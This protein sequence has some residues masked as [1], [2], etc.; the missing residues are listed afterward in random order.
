MKLNQYAWSVVSKVIILLF[1]IAVVSCQSDNPRE[2]H[3]VVILADMTHDDGNS[4]EFKGNIADPCVETSWDSI[5]FN[6]WIG[7]EL[8]PHGETKNSE[9]SEFWHEIFDKDDDRPI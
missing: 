9:W 7:E 5:Y 2:K 4:L 3:H 1:F 8:N 6:D